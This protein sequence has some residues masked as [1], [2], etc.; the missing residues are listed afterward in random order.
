MKTQFGHRRFFA[1]SSSPI[2][3]VKFLLLPKYQAPA[4]VVLGKER[5]IFRVAGVELK[6]PAASWLG[7]GRAVEF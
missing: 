4:L 1:L 3:G 7:I 6:T 2:D 5:T